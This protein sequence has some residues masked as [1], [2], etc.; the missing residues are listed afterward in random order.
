MPACTVRRAVHPRWWPCLA[1]TL[2][3]PPRAPVSPP[4]PAPTGPSAPMVP[5]PCALRAALGVRTDLV[6]P[7]AT[8]RAQRGTTA[9]SALPPRRGREGWLACAAGCRSFLGPWALAVLIHVAD[10]AGGCFSCGHYGMLGNRVHAQAHLWWAGVG[11]AGSSCVLPTWVGLS[12][13][14]GHRQLLHGQPRL[15]SPPA[16]WAVR[17]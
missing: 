3:G 5:R 17:L 9:P 14:C 1:S 13:P 16:Q 7:G 11:P 4:C 8:A 12:A 2:W 6:T 15:C 10:V